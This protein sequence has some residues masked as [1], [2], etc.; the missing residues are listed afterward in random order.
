M[1]G[2]IGGASF[3]FNNYFVV[4]G[5]INNLEEENKEKILN[6]LEKYKLKLKTFEG[7]DIIDYGGA[8]IY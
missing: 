2:F 3:V 7:L 1:K 6:H 8:I 5:D 4:F